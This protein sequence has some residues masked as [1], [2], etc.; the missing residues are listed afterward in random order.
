LALHGNPAAQ[1][2]FGTKEN[3][4]CKKTLLHHAL[5]LALPSAL[6]VASASAFA[7]EPEIAA[8]IAITRT[9]SDTQLKWGGCPPFLPKG[10]A[11]TVLHGDPAKG[12][13][14]VLLKVPA[15]S[16]IPRHWHTSA[17]RM[18]LV[19]GVLQVRYD[20][21]QMAVLRAGNYAYGPAKLPHQGYCASRTPCVL[22][23]AFETPL[24][25]IPMSDAD[26]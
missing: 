25:A 3:I 8:E 15:K 24:D 12:N 23:I 17:E 18:I 4:M 16:T 20:Q 22:F 9:L 6:L 10:C 21:Q 7:Q 26:K 2:F 5:L 1:H 11:L 13:F 19:Q 14:D